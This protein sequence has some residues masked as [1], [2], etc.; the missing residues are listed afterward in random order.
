LGEHA[1]QFGCGE[2]D[3][4]IHP[5]KSFLPRSIPILG[6]R[7]CNMLNC[8]LADQADALLVMPFRKMPFAGHVR[9]TSG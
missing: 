4:V 9:Q 5:L 6:A 7:C 2:L 1:K 3:G 8:P